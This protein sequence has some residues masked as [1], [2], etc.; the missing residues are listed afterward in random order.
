MSHNLLSDK[1]YDLLTSQN[2]EIKGISE[3]KSRIIEK[4]DRMMTTLRIIMRSQNIDQ[5]Y[6]DEIFSKEKIT[7]L[8][9]NL[10]S[11]DNEATA[12]QEKN[13]QE[14]A[15][16]LMDQSLRYFQDRYKEIFIRRVIKEFESFAKDIRE[17]TNKQIDETRAQ[18][19]HKT[20]QSLQ[21]PFT[22]PLKRCLE[23]TMHGM[24]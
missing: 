9:N 2:S 22:I 24:S 3:Q 13:K 4:A 6:K 23:S 11:Y 12:L 7:S 21:P 17:F 1:Q 15:L 19:L 14:I 5:Q 20:R 10:M 18:E 8:I 16:D